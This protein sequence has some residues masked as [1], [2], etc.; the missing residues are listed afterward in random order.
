MTKIE[1]HADHLLNAA[2]DLRNAI[3]AKRY[4]DARQHAASVS[5]HRSVIIAIIEAVEELQ[6]PPRE[7][8]PRTSRGLRPYYK[9]TG[10]LVRYIR[11]Q[12]RDI[13][14][15]QIGFVRPTDQFP[16]DRL[17]STVSSCCAD[18]WGAGKYISRKV[19]DP[20]NGTAVMQVL[21]D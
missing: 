13:A 1:E 16:I 8:H 14:P 19:V 6:P 15:G 20:E 3:K 7:S 18:M 12:I 11:E 2:A 9:R 10:E 17:Q 4:D 21:R 5:K